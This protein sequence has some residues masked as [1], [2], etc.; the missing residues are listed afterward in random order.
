MAALAQYVCPACGLAH[1]AP[2]R[3]PTD[4]EPLALASDPMLGATVG[5]YRVAR[6]L[7][8]GGMGRVYL[9]V[10]PAI[11]SRVAIKVLT[12]AAGPEL[13][14]RLFAEAYAVNV[15]RHDNIVDVLDHDRLP[16]GR[17]YLVMEYVTGQTLRAMLGA[18]A[19]P[20]A[21]VVAVLQDVLDALDAAHRAGIVHRDLKPENIMVST[22]G[23]TKVLDFGIAKLGDGP[24]RR[25]RTGVLM[26]TPAYM[27]PE[28]IL[29]EAVGPGADV[30]AAGVVLYEATTGHLPFDA[31]SDYHV[32]RAHVEQA[33]P[34]P[35]AHR[36]DMPAALEAIILR[37]LAKAPDARFADARAMADALA[38]VAPTLPAEPWRPAAATARSP[39]AVTTH[40]DDAALTAQDDGAPTAADAGPAPV[41]DQQPTVNARRGTPV[42]P[43][44]PAPS[45]A[46][47]PA[48]SPATPPAPPPRSRRRALAVAGAGLA[49]AAAAVALQ[50]TRSGDPATA[51]ID[52]AAASAPPDAA[53]ALADAALATAAVA[54]L[55]APPLDAAP[56][57]ATPRLDARPSLDA[58][59][60]RP[61]A[62]PPTDASATTAP[63]DP[64]TE[65]AR[66]ALTASCTWGGIRLWGKVKRVDFNGQIK[67]K[68]VRNLA[69]LHVKVVDVMADSCGR[70]KWVDIAPDF[71]VEFVDIFED[72]RIKYVDDMPGVA[73]QR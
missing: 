19:G 30:Y 48:P 55:D 73:I 51:P 24:A 56:V 25:T 26:G 27:A 42:A 49:I 61:D 66:P 47:P 15:I 62:A 39:Q 17:A 46:A 63:V 37:A 71:T 41:V 67:I 23:R 44:P 29:G 70:W 65:P 8:A 68:L 40:D 22:S 20:L 16:D 38:E 10:Q 60:G 53:V 35:R 13:I 9:G 31:R 69:D 45:P 32:M 59:S 36:P 57:D 18:G 1:D 43:T 28:Q 11:N 7:G 21:G 50:A 3:C 5:R 52:A 2:G 64:P 6:L 4:G 72:L 58:R 54:P 12:D 33:P 14:D 34:A